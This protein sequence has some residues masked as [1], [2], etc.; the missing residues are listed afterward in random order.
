M[1]AQERLLQVARDRFMRL[2]EV[3]HYNQNKKE[4]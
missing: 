2:T 3:S 1:Y 4:L